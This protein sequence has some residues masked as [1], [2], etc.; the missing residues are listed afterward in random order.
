MLSVQFGIG[1][2]DGPVRDLV[3]RKSL[4]ETGS[5]I[6]EPSAAFRGAFRGASKDSGWFCLVIRDRTVRPRRAENGAKNRGEEKKKKKKK[7][8]KAKRD[9]DGHVAL[10][11]EIS[12][13]AV[14]C[15]A[16]QLQR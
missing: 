16:P 14:R 8:T 9:D 4:P 3:F 1:A 12:L 15:T 2:V 5:L 11:D 10:D 7:R 13:S 6:G